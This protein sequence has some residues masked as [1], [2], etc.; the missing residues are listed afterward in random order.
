MLE[1]GEAGHAI[2]VVRRILAR[3]PHHRDAHA[4]AARALLSV[5]QHGDAVA[6]ADAWI[7]AFPDDAEAHH[8]RGKALLNL[9]K[10][11]EAR[12]AFDRAIALSP[13]LVQAMWLR[14]SVDRMLGR[15]R[16][17]T[18]TPAP[19]A[20]DLPP[21]PLRDALLAGR[22]ADAIAL[23]AREQDTPSRLR[24]ANLLS[25]AGRFEEAL[26]VF[27]ALDG[28]EALSGRARALLDLGRTDE[29]LAIVERVG[30]DGFVA[31]RR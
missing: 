27:Q 14:T 30:S 25:Y 21:G 29:A 8:A 18:G 16:A 4:L 28:A 15:L 10:L 13:L 20:E 31:L 24:L 5:K 26:H 9:R 2:D 3:A 12:D 19:M 22:I 6:A 23:L 1:L 7:A 11:V 17:A